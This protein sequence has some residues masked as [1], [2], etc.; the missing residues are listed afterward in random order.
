MQRKTAAKTRRMK[1]TR[2]RMRMTRTTMM[3]TML[4]LVK[5]HS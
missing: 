3:V 5:E 2:T 1:T 4:R